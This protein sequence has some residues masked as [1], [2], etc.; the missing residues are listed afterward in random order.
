MNGLNLDLFPVKST[1]TMSSQ[2]SETNIVPSLVDDAINELNF[3]KRYDFEPVP[4]ASTATI[5][6]QDPAISLATLSLIIRKQA[7]FNKTDKY[8]KKIRNKNLI[9]NRNNEEHDLQYYG[10]QQVAFITN[11]K[12]LYRVFNLKKFTLGGRFYGAYHESLSEE[13]RAQITIDGQKTVELD[14]SGHH[15]RMSYHLENKDYEGNPY[16]A[17]AGNE[18]E[19]KIFKN[20]CLVA[21][22]AADEEKAIKGFRRRNIS[23]WKEV[24]LSDEGIRILLDRVKKVHHRIAN[25]I[26]SEKGRTLQYLDSQITEA[27]LMRMTGQ[28]IPCLPIHDSYIVPAQY[29]EQLLEAMMVEYRQVMGFEPVVKKK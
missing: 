13:S 3:R 8:G 15:L 22:N 17:L 24:D 1:A 11:Q 4:I 10:V 29:E 26:H 20:L 27:I 7:F 21:I 6:R 12:K 2:D 28:D 23:R 18:K 19:K 14:Y 16:W 5:S 9:K 25:Y